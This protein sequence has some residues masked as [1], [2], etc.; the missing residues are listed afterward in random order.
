[1]NRE[2]FL[3]RAEM[4]VAGRTKVGKQ[5]PNGNDGQ[6]ALGDE[7][8]NALCAVTV[9]AEAELPSIP[10]ELIFRLVLLG[11]A[12]GATLATKK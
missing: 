9:G 4:G 2:E 5:Y 8:F 10:G 1:M 7:C 6:V 3:H 11:A 12:V